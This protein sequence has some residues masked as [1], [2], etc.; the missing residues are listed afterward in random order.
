M[1]H[2]LHMSPRSAFDDR[3]IFM[4]PLDASPNIGQKAPVFG[5]AGADVD[6]LFCDLAT[7]ELHDKRGRIVGARL[8]RPVTRLG[9]QIADGL[10]C[11]IA[12]VQT[13]DVFTG[14]SAVDQ[15]SSPLSDWISHFISVFADS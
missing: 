8:S 14:S 2:A 1:K 6:A 5:A 4:E 12:T 3:S 9:A 10:L 13:P 11:S 15:G 7:N